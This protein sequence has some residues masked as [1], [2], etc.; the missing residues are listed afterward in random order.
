MRNTALVRR[1]IETV[2][3]LFAAFSGFL[4]N[5]APP[6]EIHP[7]FATGTASFAV[8]ALLLFVS[9]L[10]PGGAKSIRRGRWLT[11][12]ML[13]L[14]TSLAS[15]VIYTVILE[16]YTFAYPP[17]GIR[18]TYVRGAGY[19][20]AAARLASEG[21]APSAIVA[22]FGGLQ[23]RELVWSPESL[24]RARAILLVSYLTMVLAIAAAVF[25][26]LEAR[27]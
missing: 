19:T 7:G 11:V 1:G 27:S 24:Q 13:L 25:C 4:K 5:V 21:L 22:K 10:R 18:S 8:L 6:D 20:S 15:S 23:N 3:F 12:G 14:A 2:T 26:F 9:S 16:R 17:E